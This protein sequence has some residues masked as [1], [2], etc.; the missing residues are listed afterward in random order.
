[1]NNNYLNSDSWKKIHNWCYFYTKTAA[2]KIQKRTRL[3]LRVHWSEKKHT[4]QSRGKN[5]RAYWCMRDKGCQRSSLH[6]TD[7][8]HVPS[9]RNCSEEYSRHKQALCCG[10]WPPPAICFQ[11]FPVLHD[12]LTVGRH[13]KRSTLADDVRGWCCAV[14]KGERRAE[15]DRTGAVEGSEALEKRGMKEWRAKTEFMCLNG[16]TL[17]SVQ[18]QSA[19]LPHVSEFKYLISILQS[20]GDPLNTEVH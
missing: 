13:Q 12:G 6:Q 2:I 5:C 3:T 20:D 4:T 10:S 9:M 1:M 14:R 16:T 15:I 18:M 7:E 17:G 11:S 8:G 19:Q